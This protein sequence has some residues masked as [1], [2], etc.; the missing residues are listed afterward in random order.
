[1]IERLKESSGGVIGFK[2]IGKMTAEDIKASS[3]KSAISSP[4]AS[5]SP[6]ASSPTSPRCTAP[7]WRRAGTRCASCRSTPTTSRAWRWSAPASGR[8]LWPSSPP[9]RPCSSPRRA[10][11]TAPKS[12]TPGSGSAP[13][14]TPKTFPCARSRPPP[15]SGRTTIRNTWACNKGLIGCDWYFTWVLRCGM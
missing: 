11:S 12:C 2:V 4:S 6:S 9:A 3:R 5:T 15:A 13:P 14:N 8:R 1:M 10:T 7:S